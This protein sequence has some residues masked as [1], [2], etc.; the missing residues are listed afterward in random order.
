MSVSVQELTV[1]RLTAK[2]RITDSFV[3]V[4]ASML[5]PFPFLS[6]SLVRT[7]NSVTTLWHAC[8]W[9]GLEK[10]KKERNLRAAL[11]AHC[12][13]VGWL[14]TKWLT[15]GNRTMPWKFLYKFLRFAFFFSFSRSLDWQAVTALAA[16]YEWSRLGKEKKRGTYSAL[17]TLSHTGQS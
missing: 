3:F 10:D 4:A 7:H 6:F 15:F 2:R 17:R 9:S 13:A 14:V 1:E 5:S 16:F 11:T 8:A 12:P